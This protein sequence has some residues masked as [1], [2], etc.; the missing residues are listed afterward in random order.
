MHAGRPFERPVVLTPT[1]AGTSLAGLKCRISHLLTSQNQLHTSPR[2][3]R[4]QLSLPS[5]VHLLVTLA[6]CQSAA[7]P[8]SIMKL[9]TLLMLLTGLA[10]VTTALPIPD[11]YAELYPRTEANADTTSLLNID[12]GGAILAGLCVW[13]LVVAFF[14]D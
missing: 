9:A 14:V 10:A 13:S 4:R 12:L 7:K 8:A 3:H 11:T 2:H 6:C 1:P 5:E